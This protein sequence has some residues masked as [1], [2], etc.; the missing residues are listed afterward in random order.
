MKAAE[1]KGASSAGEMK[2]RSR[3]PVLTIRASHQVIGILTVIVF[4]LTGQYMDFHQPAMPELDRGVRMMFRSTHIYILVSG[5]LNIAIGTYLGYSKTRWRK[6]LQL[7]GSYLILAGPF[8]LVAA[9][10]Y[11][12]VHTDLRRPITEPAMIGLLAGTLCHM[13]GG[14]ARTKA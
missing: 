11:E 2:A 13:V 4:L 5:L 8:L 10:F 7:V 9:F 12:P 14:T 3:S 6:A 1:A